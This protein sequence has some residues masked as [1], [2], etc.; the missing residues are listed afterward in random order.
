VRRSA[1]PQLF[2]IFG[3]RRERVAPI[4][5]RDS[6]VRNPTRGV[7][8][9]HRIEALYRP[10]ELKRV[11]QSDRTIEL[12]LTGL[13]A[14]GGKAHRAELPAIFMLMV[15]MVL[16]DCA[17]DRQEYQWN[18]CGESHRSPLHAERIRGE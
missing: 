1:E 7:S 13:V 14:R 16:R 18:D 15:L 2:G 11:Q 9:Q 10:A 17:R 4:A 12:C 3:S 8:L 5:E 6:P